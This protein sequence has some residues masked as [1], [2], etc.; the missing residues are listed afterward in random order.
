VIARLGV[1]LLLDSR[2]SQAEFM[3]RGPMENYADR[4]RGFDVG[5]WKSTVAEQMTPYEK[6]MEC[7]NHEDVR[8]ASVTSTG[9]TGIMAKAD[10]SMLQ[11]SMLPYSD[12]EMDK[13]EYRIDLPPVRSTVFCISAKTLGVGT[14]GCGPRPLP[15]YIVYAE[16][17]NFSYI[18]KLLKK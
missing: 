10:S 17:A 2:L 6:P 3:G 9:G 15:Q 5:L 4:K 11:V 7:G 16:P 12:E 14:A 13:V 18:L 1:R 8:W